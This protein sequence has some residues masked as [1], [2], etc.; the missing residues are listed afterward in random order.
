MYD[1]AVAIQLNLITILKCPPDDSYYC[2]YCYNFI[3]VIK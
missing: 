2:K 3:N 1:I